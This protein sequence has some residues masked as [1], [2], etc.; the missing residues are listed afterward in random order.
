MDDYIHESGMDFKKDDVFWIEKSTAYSAL[1][2]VR[3]VEFVRIKE[4]RLMLH[5]TQNLS[6]SELMPY[7]AIYDISPCWKPGFK[8]KAKL[9]ADRN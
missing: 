2:N 5:G 6:F 9:F 1:E 4:N 7:F 8:R 3:S